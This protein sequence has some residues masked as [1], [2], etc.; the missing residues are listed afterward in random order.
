METT[1]SAT[2]LARRLSD[3]LNR[4]K[5]RGERFAIQRNGETLATLAPRTA[6]SGTTWAEFTAKVRNLEFPGDGFAD[7]IEAIQAAQG[8]AEMPE[9]PD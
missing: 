7:D 5:Y 1:I 3:I 2:E 9:W 6:A 4:V 8:L